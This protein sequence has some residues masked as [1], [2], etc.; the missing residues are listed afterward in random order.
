MVLVLGDPDVLLSE[1]G[2]VV[3]EAVRRCE[4]LL[5]AW[6]DDLV[7]DRFA[8]DGVTLVE[9]L[10]LERSP[11]EGI[12]VQTGGCGDRCL[13]HFIPVP[14]WVPLEIDLHR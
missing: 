14:V 6:W 1:Q 7:S 8:G 11:V 3:L 13:P 2:P 9:V 12:Y 10:D 5:R 4:E